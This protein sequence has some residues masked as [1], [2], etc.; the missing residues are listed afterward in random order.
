MNGT[1]AVEGVLARMEE[2][3]S[4]DLP[5]EVYWATEANKGWEDQWVNWDDLGGDEDIPGGWGDAR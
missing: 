1:R 4:N 3:P 5:N 2:R